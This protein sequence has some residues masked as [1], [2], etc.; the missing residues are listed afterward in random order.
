MEGL[1]LAVAVVIVTFNSEKVVG[2]CLDSLAEMPVT[3][4]VV[5]N[6]S[7]DGTV[8]RVR[9]RST[10]RLIAN[11]ENRGFAGAVNEG[12]RATED[13]F[14]LLLNP[15]TRVLTPIEPL[16]N[17]S[18]RAGLSAGRLVDSSRKTQSGFT[19]RRF[20]TPASLSFELFGINRLWPANPVNRKY[21]YLDRDLDLS[22]DV[23]QPAGAFL[24]T[25]RDVWERLSG[26]DEGFHPIWFEDVDYCRRAY[27]AGYRIEYVPSVSAVH[28]GGHSIAQIPSGCRALYWCVSLLR[29]AAKHFSSFGYRA[30]CGAVL[31]SSVPRMFAGMIQERSL[32]PIRVCSKIVRIAG[33]CL[34]SVGRRGV[35]REANP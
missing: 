30:V 19:I 14:I 12:I 7:T 10:V 29:Y 15:D 8:E 11:A 18:R 4:I 27:E 26:F 2:A 23:E 17:A 16:V 28:A 22:G 1:L 25:R 13:E 32:I 20:P 33:L 24:M 6:A 9:A 34:V 35:I 21:R 5:D 31:F 3:T